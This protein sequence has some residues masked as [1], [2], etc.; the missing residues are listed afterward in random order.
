[1]KKLLLLLPLL[2]LAATS[3][4]Q[5]K[6]ST[7]NVILIFMDDMGYGDL[8]VTGAL[9]YHTPVLDALANNGLR[10][11]DFTVPQAVCSASRSALLTGNYPNRMGIQGAY[12]PNAGLGLAPEEYTLAELMQDQG[13]TTQMIGK[14][15]LGNEPQFLP[16]NQG[17]SAYFGLPYSNDMWPVEFDGTPAK[18][19]SP[20]AK[21]PALPLLRIKAGQVVPDTV[22]IIETLDDQAALTGLYTDKAVDFIRE[23]R[24]SPFFLYLAHSMTH[25]PIAASETFKGQSEQGVFGDVMM[26]VDHAIGRIISELKKHNLEENTLVIFT[27]D[28]GPWL[29][30]GNHN[31]SSGGFREGKGASWEGGVRVPCIISWPAKIHE[32]TV[33]NN[34]VSSMDIFATIAEILGNPKTP[35]TIDGISFLNQLG[36]PLAVADRKSLY[37]YYNR[38][39]LEAVRFEN[40]KLVFPHTYRSYEDVLPGND[41]FPGKYNHKQ[42]EA[43][44]LYDLRRDPAERYNVIQQHPQ[45]LEKLLEIA[46][47]ARNDLG[48]NLQKQ[49]GKNRR[50][51]GRIIRGEEK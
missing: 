44:E 39:D 2:T 1:M 15:H 27:S 35:H 20:Y 22:Q 11:T 32:P 36:D 26:E 6:K 29:N 18:K 10:F 13:Y 46:D 25:V 14:W 8:G 33:N 24:K 31:G 21:Y 12:M 5:V 49:E 23:N 42:V 43:M 48:D 34:L 38:N 40:W 16:T 30:F 17:F 50:P 9:Q 51:V 47:E 3:L 41:G 37:Y 19:D 45:V 28:N 7:P 4:A